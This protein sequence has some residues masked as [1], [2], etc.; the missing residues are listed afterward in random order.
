MRTNIET[1]KQMITD[2]QRQ[3]NKEADRKWTLANK[4]TDR[5]MKHKTKVYDNKQINR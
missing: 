5:K 2:K 1:E 3:T 4:K